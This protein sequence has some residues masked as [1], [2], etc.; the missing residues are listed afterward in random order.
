MIGDSD[1]TGNG[2]YPEQ[3]LVPSAVEGSGVQNLSSHTIKGVC[4]AVPD[5]VGK[6]H[7]DDRLPGNANLPIGVGF[8]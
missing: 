4:H 7:R 1:P 2:V 6:G 8:R 3:P 5:L